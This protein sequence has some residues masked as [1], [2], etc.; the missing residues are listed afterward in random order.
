MAALG[1]P[2]ELPPELVDLP[3]PL[4]PHTGEEGPAA[5]LVH[6]TEPKTSLYRG[7][8]KQRT[9]NTT[10]SVPSHFGSFLTVK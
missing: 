4:R 7:S 8:E 1:R 6:G 2:A 5:H 9:E 3:A 10:D